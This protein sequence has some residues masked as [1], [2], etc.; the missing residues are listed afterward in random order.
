[1]SQ[2]QHN[3]I[4]STSEMDH[5]DISDVQEDLNYDEDSIDVAAEEDDEEKRLEEEERERQADLARL[6]KQAEDAA[7]RKEEIRLKKEAAL[8]TAKRMR[9]E[10]AKKKQE[11]EEQ[12]KKD[13]EAAFVEEQR[14]R[15]EE[16][17]TRK[18]ENEAMLHEDEL[19]GPLPTSQQDLNSLTLPPNSTQGIEC[20]PTPVHHQPSSRP[21]TPALLVPYTDDLIHETMRLINMFQQEFR[22]FQRES[23]ST[24]SYQSAE[25][26]AMHKLLTQHIESV[27]SDKTV[28]TQSRSVT[29]SKP[30]GQS[31]KSSSSST[32]SN[33]NNTK[34][35]K[36]QEEE[37]QQPEP[38]NKKAKSSTSS[39]SQK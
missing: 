34:K 19:A 3:F 29:I 27:R 4:P 33:N 6:A 30:N 15:H 11:A 39:R 31:N 1:M 13:A 36:A 28:V 18:R 5:T 21:V 32:N 20:P 12:A 35:R 2:F 8:A 14:R 22:Q 9:E 17:E 38:S 10:A 37:A 26:A 23:V 24:Q 16:E 7:R 25:I